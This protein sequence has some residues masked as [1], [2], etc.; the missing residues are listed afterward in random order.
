MRSLGS[1]F[2]VRRSPTLAGLEAKAVDTGF[3]L[4]VKI[5]NYVPPLLAKSPS[6][7]DAPRSGGLI[8]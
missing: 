3:Y 8:R 7:L 2:V 4:Q 1:E 6:L 5:E